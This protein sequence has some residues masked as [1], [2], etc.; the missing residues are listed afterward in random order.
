MLKT[1]VKGRISE[2]KEEKTESGK[3]VL[4]FSV[5]HE[6]KEKRGEDTL[7]KTQWVEIDLWNFNDAVKKNEKIVSTELLLKGQGVQV[8]GVPFIDAWNDKDTGEI[9]SKLRVNAQGI[10]LIEIE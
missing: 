1:I 6:Y 4:K 3:S 8:T 9:K 5:A 2:P 7:L 10:E